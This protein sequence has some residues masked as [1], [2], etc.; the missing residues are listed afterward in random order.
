ML[1]ISRE[2]G[3]EEGEEGV[4]VLQ[5]RSRLEAALERQDGGHHLV[6]IPRGKAVVST[7]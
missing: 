6:G 2:E 3:E 4:G 5:T 7:K 1:V